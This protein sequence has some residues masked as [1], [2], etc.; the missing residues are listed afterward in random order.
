MTRTVILDS[1]SVILAAS[2]SGPDVLIY[3]PGTFDS[4]SV[5]VAGVRYTGLVYVGATVDGGPT[6]NKMLP[7]HPYQMAI[8]PFGMFFAAI[9]ALLTTKL[10][11]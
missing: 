8:L 3:G 10:R 6:V 1:T 11:I 2:G 7:L 9:I 4:D 5:Y